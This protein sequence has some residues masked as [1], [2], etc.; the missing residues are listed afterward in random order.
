MPESTDAPATDRVVKLPV[1]KLHPNPWNRTLFDPEPLT[2]LTGNIKIMGVK[3]PLIVRPMPD[4]SHQIASGNRR[5]LAAQA[6]GLKEVPCWIQPLTDEQVAEMN[7][8]SNVQ[9]EDVPPLELARMV[10]DY[11]KK[12]G[13]TQQEAADK[14][15]RGLDWVKH[16]LGFLNMPPE[17]L[18]RCSVLHLGWPQ[19][20]ALKRLP[21]NH[22]LT[23]AEEIKTGITKPQ[24]VVKRAKQLKFTPKSGQKVEQSDSGNAIQ[25]NNP[26]SELPTAGPGNGL[27]LAVPPQVVPPGLVGQMVAAGKNQAI[28]QLLAPLGSV[29][30]V[31][32]KAK[33]LKTWQVVLLG[34]LGF[35]VLHAFMSLA[36][37]PTR[38]A[39]RFWNRTSNNSLVRSAA[40]SNP[41]TAAI[42]DAPPK[43]TASTLSRIAAPTG[44]KAEEILSGQRV[45]FSWNAV[46]GCAGY[47]FYSI[48]AWDST[49]QWTKETKQPLLEPHGVWRNT[50]G[51]DDYKFVATAVIDPDHESAFSEPVEVDM[52]QVP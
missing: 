29:G 11:I 21:P 9:R 49:G 1:D 50:T 2:E 48:R 5:W 12:F 41:V 37:L 39:E 22:Q 8:V 27:P 19:L 7:V 25:Q 18:D 35:F 31:L 42:G 10:D 33:G 24:E 43:L 3:E 26:K 17:V 40:A 14:F 15:G 51:R 52:R 13:K 45:R 20:E 38:L 32:Q 47:N 34:S 23:V 44:L 6:A 30:G 4:G 28:G 46:P 16:L 36:S